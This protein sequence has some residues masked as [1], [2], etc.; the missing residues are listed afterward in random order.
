[1]HV[2][3][4]GSIALDHVTVTD[5]GCDTA[6]HSLG[7]GLLSPGEQRTYRCRHLVRADTPDRFVTTA[8]VRAASAV[9]AAHASA[10]AATRV[11]KPTLSISVIPDPA[12]GTAGAAITYRYIVRNTGNTTLT[13]LR[14]TDDR[15]GSVGSAPQ[16]APGHSVRF[17]VQRTLT[18]THVWVTNTATVAAHDASGRRVTANDRSS[19]TTV[20]SNGSGDGT[21]FTGGDA[22]LPGIAALALA[23][24]GAASMLLAARRRS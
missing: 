11:L 19:V 4:S 7:G 2:T 9:G 20:G 18:A 15:L 10:R 3:N 13:D 24:V 6:P 12:S 1:M 22:T 23:L 5:P 21:A 16:L 8:T 14:V 17:S